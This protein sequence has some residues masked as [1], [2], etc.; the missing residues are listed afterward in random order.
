MERTVQIVETEQGD[1]VVDVEPESERADKVLA[2]LES[3]VVDSGF[4]GT[5]FNRLPARVHAN[6]ELEGV[7]E[8]RVNLGPVVLEAG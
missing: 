5:H 6:L 7:D 8:G 3:A 4:G 2:L 1:G